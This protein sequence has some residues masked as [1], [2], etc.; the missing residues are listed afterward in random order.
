[1]DSYGCSF[2]IRIFWTDKKEKKKKNRSFANTVET[3][4]VLIGMNRLL[5]SCIHTLSY[6]ETALKIRNDILLYI[7]LVKCCSHKS[8]AKCLKKKTHRIYVIWM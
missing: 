1:M 4:E 7:L 6:E 5:V 8:R 3:F 2:L